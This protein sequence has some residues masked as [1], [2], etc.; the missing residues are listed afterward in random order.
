MPPSL[1]AVLAVV[2]TLM[3]AAA[4]AQAPQAP[5]VTVAAAEMREITVAQSFVGRVEAVDAAELVA[6]VTGFLRDIA[7]ADGARV[8]EGEVLF[9]IERD[10]YAASVAARDA[11]LARAEANLSL[12]RVELDRRERLVA[13]DAAP[14]SELDV[15]RANLQ[16]AEA[17]VAGAEA[18]LRQAELELSYTTVTAPFDGRVGRIGA[19]LGDIVGPN[20]GTL[21]TLVREQPVFVSFALAERQMTDVMQAAL[22]AGEA[23]GQPPADLPVRVELPNGT[24]LAETGTLAFAD[25]RIDPGTG[26][27]TVRARFDNADRLLVPGGF[28]TVRIEA[29]RPQPR[30]VIPQAAIQRDQ[31]GA[32]VLVVGPQQTVEQRYVA[33]GRSLGPDIVVEDGLAPGEAVIVEGLQRVRPGV[34]VEALRAGGGE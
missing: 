31:R 23:T 22:A 15:A 19:S 3:P 25:N 4:G 33:T 21:A 14:Q 16:V 13:R 18:A 17:E 9:R 10:Q 24:A 1:L 5:R 34:P 30:L 12:A 20:S 28:V 2:V 32:F 29:A 27:L 26:T 11:D 7:V 6:R 8:S